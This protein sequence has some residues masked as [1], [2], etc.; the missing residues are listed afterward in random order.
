MI[1]PFIEVYPDAHW[2][3]VGDGYFGS[4]AHFLRKHGATVLSTSLTDA[5]L[6]IARE[7]GFIADYKAVNAENM[8]VATNSFDFVLCKESY[9]HFPRPPIALYEMLRVARKAVILFE[10]QETSRRVLDWARDVARMVVRRQKALC[11]EPEPCANFIYRLNL[12]E[13][14]KM[15]TALNYSTIAIRKLNDFYHAKLAVARYSRF[16]L[17][18]IATKLC[19]AIQDLL[20]VLRM[21]DYSGA[22]VVLFTATP[23]RE[24]LK[25]L[26]KNGFRVVHLPENPYLH[27]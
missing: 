12:K 23:D 5:T 19:I 18:T 20:C 7:R 22:C 11:F 25:A 9:H 14:R 4:N 15:M 1:L 16:S 21:L 13:L 17:P 27:K 6:V 2:L 26:A 10:P 24:F 3:T 8:E